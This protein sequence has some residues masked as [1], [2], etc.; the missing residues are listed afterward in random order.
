MAESLPDAGRIVD[1]SLQMCFAPLSRLHLRNSSI[2]ENHNLRESASPVSSER[3]GQENGG[4]GARIRTGESGF[5]RPLP[6][7]LATPPRSRQRAV[8]TPALSRENG[9][10]RSSRVSIAPVAAA[11]GS[12]SILKASPAV[13]PKSFTNAQSAGSPD[14]HLPGD[15]DHDRDQAADGAAGSTPSAPVHA[16]VRAAAVA[17]ACGRASTNY[18]APADRDAPVRAHARPGPDPAGYTAAHSGADRITSGGG[19]PGGAPIAHLAAPGHR[20]N[21]D[22]AADRAGGR[23]ADA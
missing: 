13:S 5:C 10:L 4:G 12:C 15:P 23:G 8:R 2:W 7:L 17:D 20:N 21:P 14:C 18:P 16:R 22:R 3:N 11:T 1:G 9:T 19:A 6:C